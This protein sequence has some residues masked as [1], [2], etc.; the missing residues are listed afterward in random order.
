MI[1]E[2]NDQ[3]NKKRILI[4]VVLLVIVAWPFYFF[5]KSIFN[6]NVTEHELVPVN[7]VVEKELVPT[8]VVDEI[9]KFDVDSQN[10]VSFKSSEYAVFTINFNKNIGEHIQFERNIDNLK[11]KKFLNNK[12]QSFG[13]EVRENKIFNTREDFFAMTAAMYSDTDNLPPGLVISNGQLIKEINTDKTS[14]GNFFMQPNGVF[15]INENNVEITETDNF[16]TNTDYSFAIQSGPM[17]I[18][19]NNINPS[20]DPNS[21]NKN[22]RCAIGIS[23]S[24][25][26]KKMV[27]AIS[28]NEVTF[29]EL[30]DLLLSKYNCKTALHMESGAFPFIYWPGCNYPTNKEIIKNFILIR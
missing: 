10:S 17:I 19:D 27:F 9:I 8:P 5:I 29:Y 16:N 11:T 12:I 21:A 6:N 18:I 28:K 26:G 4:I 24:T 7:T 13:N 22:R 25:E 1:Y 20:L 30:A 14:N 15:W 3:P 2:S 23:D